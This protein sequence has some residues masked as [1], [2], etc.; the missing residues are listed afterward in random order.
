MISSLLHILIV[1]PAI[2]LWLRT[3]ELRSS[4][5]PTPAVKQEINNNK[6]KS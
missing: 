3:R 4:L 5:A 6:S 2:F 1:T